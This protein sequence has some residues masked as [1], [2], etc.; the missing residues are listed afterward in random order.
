[1]FRLIEREHLETLLKEKSLSLQGLVDA[2]ESMKIGSLKEAN[3]MMVIDFQNNIF[4]AKIVDLHSGEILS[5]VTGNF[6]K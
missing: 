4:S 6:N 2:D 3:L 1:M 5:F